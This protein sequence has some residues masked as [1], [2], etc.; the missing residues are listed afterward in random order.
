MNLCV[1]ASHIHRWLVSLAEGFYYVLLV[2]LLTGPFWICATLV[3]LA[4]SS[5]LSNFLE[6]MGSPSFQFHKG[7]KSSL[8]LKV[9][10]ALWELYRTS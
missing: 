5:N 6:K 7:E 2:L 4:L 10:L 9:V 3:T 8:Q 1:A